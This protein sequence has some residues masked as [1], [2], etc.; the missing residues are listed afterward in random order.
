MFAGSI[1][2]WPNWAAF[3]CLAA[4]LASCGFVE[5]TTQCWGAAFVRALL[6][7]LRFLYRVLRATSTCEGEAPA[8]GELTLKTCVPPY[9]YSFRA[10]SN[11]QSS[12]QPI[13]VAAGHVWL[14][15]ASAEVRRQSINCGAIPP[16]QRSTDKCE[17]QQCP[18]RASRRAR[19]R[20]AR[21]RA[22]RRRTRRR[23]RWSSSRSLPAP[24]K[25]PEL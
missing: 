1:N 20:R 2:A 9:L 4:L 16:S 23:T 5:A 19:A 6:D 11:L 3:G 24:V 12:S 22:K 14:R 13:S 8:R 25:R 7:R 15:R 21:A 10:S 18:R 17:K